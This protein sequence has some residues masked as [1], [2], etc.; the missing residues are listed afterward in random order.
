MVHYEIIELERKSIPPKTWTDT[1]K[2]INVYGI[3][4]AMSYLHSHNIIHRDLKPANILEDDN[5][6]PK[7][8]DF[9][10]SKIY[11]QNKTTESTVGF[12][13]TPIYNAPEIWIL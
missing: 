11:H 7:I 3:A 4:S 5:F 2:L 12:K 6:F 13:G 10:L 1:K 8:A 9:G